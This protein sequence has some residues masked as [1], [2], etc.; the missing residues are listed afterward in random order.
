MKSAA[1]VAKKTEEYKAAG[2]PLIWIAWKIALMCVGWAYVFGARGELC[3]PAQR[4]AF[5]R[6]KGADHPTIASKCQVIREKDPKASC[7]GCKWFPNGKRTRIFDCRG[8][9]YWILYIVYGFKLQ[10]AGA[11]SQWNTASNWKAKGKIKTI[12]ENMLVCLFQE[13]GNKMAHTGFGY[14]GETVECQV[15]VQHFTKRNAK[16]THWA[17]PA[18]CEEEYVPPAEEPKEDTVAKAYKKGSKG[19]EV[20]KIQ[21]MLLERGYKLPKYGADGSY[22]DETAAAVKQFQKDWGLKADGIVDQETLKMMEQTPAKPK[23]YTVTITG[24]DKSTAQDLCGKYKNAKM[25]EE[26]ILCGKRLLNCWQQLGE[27]LPVSLC[28]CRRWYGS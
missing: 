18:C 27:P 11:T 21:Q 3:S 2:K 8:F 22:G 14:K 9:T 28:P 23:Y 17:L 16:W 10:G 26:E 15:G 6:S 20:K 7:D 5:F 13:N 4:R 12:Q 25:K 19:S 24:L 1:F